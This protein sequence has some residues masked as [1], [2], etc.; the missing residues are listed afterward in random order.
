MINNIEKY[1]GKTIGELPSGNLNK[2]T[3]VKVFHLEL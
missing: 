1:Y 3:D 2:I